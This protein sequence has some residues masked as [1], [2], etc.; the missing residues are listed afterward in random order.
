MLLDASRKKIA[1]VTQA[2]IELGLSNV[3]A[4]ASRVEEYTANT[5]FDIVISRAL[6]DL[7]SFTQLTAH[8]LAPRGQ[9]VAM[10]GTLPRDEIEALP[11]IVRVTG[12]PSLRVPGLDAERHLVLMQ[13]SEGE[14]A[15]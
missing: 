4:V 15:R 10:K 6:S 7:R 13:A 3:E 2:A 14:S 9:W 1:F 11:A 12:T 8:L 5:P